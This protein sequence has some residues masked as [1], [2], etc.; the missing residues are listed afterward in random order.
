[1]RYSSGGS[2]YPWKTMIT[3]NFT[4]IE[5]HT[6]VETKI[7]KGFTKL[8]L[9]DKHNRPESLSSARFIILMRQSL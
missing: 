5:N 7:A 6:E 3:L 4:E 2:N 9:N 8:C 1:M